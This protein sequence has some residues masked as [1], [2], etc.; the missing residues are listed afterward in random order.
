MKLDRL[1]ADL[2]L[3]K[4]FLNQM[5]TIRMVE[6]TLLELFS[7]GYL[8]GTVH[9][10]IGQEGCAVGF[11]NALDRA[12]D[13]MFSNHRGHGH[14]LTY[15]DDVQ[16]LIA[17]IMGS[18][19]GVC[20]GVGGS[21]HLQR[22]NFYTNGI[23]GAGAPIVVGMALAEKLS[24]RNSVAVVFLGDGTFGEGAVYEAMNIASLWRLPVIFAVENN[25]YAQTTPYEMQH[26][27]DFTTRAS[28]FGIDVHKVDGMDVLAV[29]ETAIKVVAECRSTKRPQLLLMDTYRFAPHSKGDDYRDSV[30]IDFHKKRD[31]ILVLVSELGLED[32]LIK[33]RDAAKTRVDTVVESLLRGRL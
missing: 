23:Q 6:E 8:N 17:E 12:T 26:A 2:G 32:D 5:V 28:S 31:P 25:H 18:P 29:Y 15:S 13:V 11:V 9:T 33:I 21:Q 30:E 14:Y 7:K 1:S 24:G 4:T 3:A 22:E 10:C 16:G 27:G 20:G 19:D